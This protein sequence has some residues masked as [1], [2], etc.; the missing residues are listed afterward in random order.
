M[1]STRKHYSKLYL[2]FFL[3]N[4]MFF[5]TLGV[6]KPQ[7]SG[8]FVFGDSFVDNGNNNYLQTTLKVNYFPYGVDFPTGPTGRFSNG[9][10]IADFIGMHFFF[11]Y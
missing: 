8:F 3:L 10:N 4:L 2:C 9:Q 7:F 1:A 5:Q 6:S 11:F